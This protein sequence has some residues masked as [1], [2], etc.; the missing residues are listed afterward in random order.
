MSKSRSVD[1]LSSDNEVEIHPL[2]RK[3][4]S[5]TI[6]TT[7]NTTQETEDGYD[8]LRAGNNEG[9]R[10]DAA[11]LAAKHLTAKFRTKR[12]PKMKS[13]SYELC[14]STDDQDVECKEAIIIRPTQ[15]GPLVK[16]MA[17]S[18]SCEPLMEDSQTVTN[19]YAPT[20]DSLIS[21]ESRLSSYG[22]E[23]VSCCTEPLSASSQP[24]DFPGNG[25][26]VAAKLRG[27]E[28]TRKDMSSGWL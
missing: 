16:S 13:Q 14:G 9:L 11:A 24:H 23:A 2:N 3:T 5:T 27:I 25:G 22:S 1:S 20:S 28:H 17:V 4:G 8:S 19:S 6:T 15:K 7:E 10:L 18:E 26:L 12:P 21:P